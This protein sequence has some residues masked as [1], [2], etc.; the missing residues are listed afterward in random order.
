MIRSQG[1]AP[2]LAQPSPG[3]DIR[4]VH[5]ITQ[6]GTHIIGTIPCKK[7]SRDIKAKYKARVEMGQPELCG[8]LLKKWRSKERL[9]APSICKCNVNVV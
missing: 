8:E 4:P 6:T 5:I 9:D 1:G 7:T 2:L 3:S